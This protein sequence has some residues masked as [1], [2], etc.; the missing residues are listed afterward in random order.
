M[1]LAGLRHFDDLQLKMP[2]EE[3]HQIAE[4]VKSEVF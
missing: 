3:G 4:F 2:A 1:Q